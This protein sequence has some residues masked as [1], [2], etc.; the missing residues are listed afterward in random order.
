MAKAIQYKKHELSETKYPN[1][2]GLEY[3][4]VQR[5]HVNSEERV[6]TAGQEQGLVVIEGTVDVR[7]SNE[8]YPLDFCDMMYIP[9]DMEFFI[10]GSEAVLMR[11]AAPAENSFEPAVFSFNE[12]KEDPKRHV[13]V[14]ADENGSLRHV[15]KVI[16]ENFECNRLMMGLCEGSNGGWAAWPPH[17]HSEKKEE[18]YTYFDMGEDFGVQLV[19]EDLSNPLGVFIVEDG[20]VVSIGKGYH[21]NVGCPSGRINFVYCMAAKQSGERR[22]ADMNFQERFISRT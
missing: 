8:I 22:F 18:V 14:G 1:D 11:Y 6:Y 17:E 10:E 9:K 2:L 4:E 20:D 13:Q 16:D 21:P 5:L 3:I 15:W 7:I 12:V 19:Y